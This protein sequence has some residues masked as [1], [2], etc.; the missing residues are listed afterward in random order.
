M[1]WGMTPA[2]EAGVLRPADEAVA[3]HDEG[4]SEGEEGVE[5]EAG[6]SGAGD[7]FPFDRLAEGS[8]PPA[9]GG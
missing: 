7:V 4:W 5:A 3:E 8:R 1:S 6:D 9:A 2:A